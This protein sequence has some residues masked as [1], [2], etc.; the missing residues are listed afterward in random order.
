MQNKQIHT[1]IACTH[2]GKVYSLRINNGK[3]FDKYVI[4]W[5]NRY[6]G[7][8]QDEH[9]TMIKIAQQYKWEYKVYE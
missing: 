1:L 9:K 5:Y 2:D 8:T 4:A 7:E 3:P 6:M